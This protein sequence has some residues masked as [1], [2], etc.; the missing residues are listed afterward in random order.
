MTQKN[1][2]P[3]RLLIVDD[4]ADILYTLQMRLES[5]G[6]AVFIADDGVKA[7][8]SALA[9]G[10]EVVLLDLVMP[11]LSGIPL[12]AK[13]KEAVPTVEV[14]ILTAHGT[15]ENSVQAIKEGAYDYLTKPIE[16]ERLILLV[17]K[18]LEKSR[19]A[20]E[21]EDLR[22]QIRHLGTGIRLIGQTP[23]MRQ[24]RHLINRVADSNA[25]VMITGE[26]GTGKEVVARAIHEA[27]P[28]REKAFVA[29]NCAAVTETLWESEFFGYERGAFT[30]AVGRRQ[31]FFE[32]SHGG[33]LFLDEVS[34]MTADTQAKLLRVLEERTI[35]RV[36]GKDVIATD[37]RII[38][39]SNR[40]LEQAI[41]T[42]TLREDLY[43]RLNV[44][45]IPLPP[46]R[47]RREDIP[48]LIR[49]II[50]EAA[51]RNGRDVR[52]IEERA[53]E[54]LMSHAWP[55]NIRELRNVIERAV[56]MAHGPMIKATEIPPL[57]QALV[58]PNPLQV[59]IGQPLKDVERELILK[60]LAA[61]GGNKTKAATILGISLK[62]LHNKLNRYEGHG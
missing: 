61:V 14:I 37:V 59:S 8:D 38:A 15:I 2:G 51:Q 49:H 4:D 50:V 42:G 12:M 20:R 21:V 46:L 57:G 34:E 10:I 7:V 9:N 23:A 22:T 43:Y 5:R 53:T 60:T 19:I 26:S 31:G 29:V 48:L 39:A 1:G 16:N 6:Y 17:E 45:T 52:D 41:K 54:A 32:M 56:L 44:F 36:G 28:R 25:T 40:N 11:G 58:E 33:T 47:E 3:G 27:S 62:T 30:G 24:V 13:L 55:G 35:R 18:A